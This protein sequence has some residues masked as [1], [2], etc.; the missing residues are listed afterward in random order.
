MAVLKKMLA[1][2][3]KLHEFATEG[4][5]GLY[6]NAAWSEARLFLIKLESLQHQIW[7]NYSEVQSSLFLSQWAR[8]GLAP[9]ISF[10]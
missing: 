1:A 9:N 2:L 8:N 10:S 5:R 3:R 7:T 6:S 4:F